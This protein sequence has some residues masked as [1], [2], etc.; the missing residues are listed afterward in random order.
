MVDEKAKSK[1]MCFVVGP[2]VAEDSDERIHADWL[3]ELIIQPVIEE[4]PEFETRRADQIAVPGMIDAQVI[5]ALLNAELVIADLSTLN[6]NAFYEIGIRHMVQKPIIHM[7]LADEQIP[8][9]VSLYRA[10][11][12]SRLRPSDLREARVA[13]KAQVE[14]AVKDDYK[15][16]N[17]VTRARGA[18]Q[19]QQ[20]ATPTE[21]VLVRQLRVMQ[22][23]INDLS[24]MVSANNESLSR[25]IRMPGLGYGSD[26]FKSALDRPLHLPRNP[27]P[28]Q[29][30][31][32]VELEPS[33][34]ADGVAE[35]IA[36][37]KSGAT[38]R[39]EKHGELIVSY[40]GGGTV[41]S[42]MQE[43]IAN[44]PGVAAVGMK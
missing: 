4:F 32:F 21:Q 44:L 19:L 6:P 8:F 33:A 31:V 39:M 37:L 43:E 15:P 1:K 22:E 2:I 24:T 17:P 30:T 20:Y 12:F 3:L 5:N 16:E 18:L 29:W 11:K 14:A 41:H 25:G 36:E 40:S 35:R 38:I 9:D 26:L 42:R 34:S 28:K 27:A 7:Q 10:I 23:Q 13:L